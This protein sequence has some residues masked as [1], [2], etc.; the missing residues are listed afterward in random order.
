[1]E[2]GMTENERALHAALVELEA[3]AKPAPEGT[4]RPDLVGMFKRID[5]L[6]A[7]LPPDT[8]REFLHFLHRK[9]YLKAR[10]WLEARAH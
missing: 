1:M 2:S 6:A 8:D 3:A 10:E 5:A 9:S 4:P 7:T